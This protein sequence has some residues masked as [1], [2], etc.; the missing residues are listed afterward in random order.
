VQTPLP[1]SGAALTHRGAL[2]ALRT[3]GTAIAPDDQASETRTRLTQIGI[4]MLPTEWLVGQDPHHP[5]STVHLLVSLHTPLPTYRERTGDPPR[6]R[7]R[8]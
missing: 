5:R 1:S 8:R 4:R 6:V 7:H 3:T 2:P